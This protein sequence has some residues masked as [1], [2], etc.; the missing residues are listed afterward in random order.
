MKVFVLIG[1]ISFSSLGFTNR[2]APLDDKPIPVMEMILIC[3]TPAILYKGYFPTKES[4]GEPWGLVR[5]A[6]VLTVFYGV[7]TFVNWQID[8]YFGA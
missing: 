1:V 2:I 6:A 4:Q 3:L 8:S 5:N 7:W